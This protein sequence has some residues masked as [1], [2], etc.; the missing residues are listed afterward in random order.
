MPAR[1]AGSR[2][3]FL[4]TA[5]RLFV[6]N[7]YRG[8]TIRAIC[9]EAGT[10][11]GILNRHWASKEALFTEMLRRHFD[12]LH[13]QQNDRF[14][15]IEARGE[16]PE[17]SDIITAFFGPAFQLISAQ[18]DNQASIYSRAMIDPSREIK[19]LVA[20]LISETRMRLI[21][22]V[23]KALPSVGESDIFVVMNLLLGAYVFPQ[24]FG[25]QLAVAMGFNDQDYNW[26]SAIG[27]VVA[28]M[29][30][31]VPKVA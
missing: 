1:P 22:L 2:E 8:T 4:V 19:I 21:S 28:I 20:G 25:H 30:N 17:I 18:G 23:R 6:E 14:D 26:E 11:L 31:G 27:T 13:K 3:R 16:K 15:A 10:S 12:P 5:E 9:I 24:A 29:E 7:G